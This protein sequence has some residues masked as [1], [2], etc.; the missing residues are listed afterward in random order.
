VLRGHQADEG[1]ELR[2]RS[3]ALEVADL[4]RE[5]ERGQG[6]DAAQA[7][8][9]PDE[10]APGALRGRLGDR[11]LERRDPRVDEIE[12]VQVGSEGLLT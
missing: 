3:E 2:G 5:P 11:P 10:L 6:V 9:A 8:Q 7:A 1:R 12:R 4:D